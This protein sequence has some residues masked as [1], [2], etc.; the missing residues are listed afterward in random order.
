MILRAGYYLQNILLYRDAILKEGLLPLPMGLGKIAPV[1]V[2]DVGAVA[3]K[4]LS[5]LD[6]FESF[7]G[8]VINVAGQEALSGADMASCFTNFLSK[9]VVYEDVTEEEAAKTLKD[10]GVLDFEAT[11]RL[12]FMRM[13]REHDLFS[14]SVAVATLKNLIGDPMTFEKSLK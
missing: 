3:S 11:E 9:P 10:L 4:L 13:V 5:D 1:D 2:H 7:S 14:S 12:E 6:L 8:S